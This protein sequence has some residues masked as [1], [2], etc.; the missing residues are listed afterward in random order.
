MPPDRPTH[1]RRAPTPRSRSRTD[2]PTNALNSALRGASLGTGPS[3]L[4]FSQDPTL[5]LGGVFGTRPPEAWHPIPARQGSLR[6][7]AG[8]SLPA[9]SQRC[10]WVQSPTLAG[11]ETSM[12]P[13]GRA[14]SLGPCGPQTQG[15]RSLPSPALHSG[16]GG[17]HEC[18]ARSDVPA[19]TGPEA[20]LGC[21]GFRPPRPASPTLQAGEPRASGHNCISTEEESLLFETSRI[22]GAGDPCMHP[23]GHLPG[24]RP[25]GP[26]TGRLTILQTQALNSACG[27]GHVSAGSS[28]LPGPVGLTLTLGRFLSL[29]APVAWPGSPAVRGLLMDPVGLWGPPTW[30]PGPW[31]PRRTL[32]AGETYMPPD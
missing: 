20:Q 18:V 2:R 9:G 25:P 14:R 27:R 1:P 11:L 3:G 16:L 10:P 15:A 31:A 4:P 13:G 17:G 19:G 22:R 29:A 30:K 6:R 26:G 8:L 12:L 21:S 7:T 23:V 24:R 28:G 5:T 32:L